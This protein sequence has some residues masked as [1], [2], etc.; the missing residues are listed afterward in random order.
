MSGLPRPSQRMTPPPV[1]RQ[2]C[3]CWRNLDAPQRRYRTTRL[4]RSRHRGC[5]VDPSAPPTDQPAS[6]ACQQDGCDQE[7]AFIEGLIQWIDMSEEQN[8]DDDV[9]DEGATDGTY[10]T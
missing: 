5:A 6:P 10:A 1:R 2:C 9:D 3:P 8:V 7:Q 4:L